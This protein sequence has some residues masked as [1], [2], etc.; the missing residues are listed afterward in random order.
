MKIVVASIL[1]GVSMASALSKKTAY[2]L[3]TSEEHA[4]QFNLLVKKAHTEIRSFLATV[5]KDISPYLQHHRSAAALHAPG[6]KERITLDP[7]KPLAF[8]ALE[9]MIDLFKNRPQLLLASL[10][11]PPSTLLA[12]Y[13]PAQNFLAMLQALFKEA[14][15]NPHQQELFNAAVSYFLSQAELDNL[16]NYYP[17]AP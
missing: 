16:G 3:Q 10:Q 7:I 12:Q 17:A 9:E 2:K 8:A 6:Y 1:I 4:V 14:Q 11:P 13:K 15:L 5:D